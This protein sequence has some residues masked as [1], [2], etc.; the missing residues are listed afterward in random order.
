MRGKT[1][2]IVLPGEFIRKT[3]QYTS[4]DGTVYTFPV[5]EK[6]VVPSKKN[7]QRMVINKTTLKV[8]P[9]PSL[10]HEKWHKSHFS[11]FL[12]QKKKMEAEGFQLPIYRCKVKV[13]FYFPESGVRDL[14]NKFETLADIL[15]DT[16]I[17]LDDR[18]QVLKPVTLDGWCDRSRPRTEIWLTMIHPKSEHYEWDIT[19]K[20]Y[21]ISKAAEKSLRKQLSDRKR[22]IRIREKEKGFPIGHL[23]YSLIHRKR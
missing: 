10:Q 18:Y 8:M 20:E 17:I 21:T 11:F 16:G 22:R 2:K 14:S 1:F 15:T 6:I 7:S 23:L 9:M 3:E 13:Y 5:M 4:A 19:P 12:N